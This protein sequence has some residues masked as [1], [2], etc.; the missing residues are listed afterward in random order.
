[1]ITNNS[2]LTKMQLELLRGFKHITDEEQLKE[3]KSLLNLY[4]REKLNSAIEKEESERNY[5]ADI[6]IKWLNSAK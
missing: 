4:F 5:S 2:K 6:Y 3:V 1:M